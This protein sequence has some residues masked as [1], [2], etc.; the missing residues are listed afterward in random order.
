MDIFTDI[1]RRYVTAIYNG[2]TSP[3]KTQSYHYIHLHIPH[4]L[5]FFNKNPEQGCNQAFKLLNLCDIFVFLIHDCSI[6]ALE[7]YIFNE[8]NK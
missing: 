7:K 4:N 5:N 8:E 6:I 2:R 1:I 3:G